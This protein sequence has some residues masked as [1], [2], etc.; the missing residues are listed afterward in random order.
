MYLSKET[1]QK[2]RE[3]KSKSTPGIEEKLLYLPIYGGYNLAKT[4]DQNTFIHIPHAI[5]ITSLLGCSGHPYPANHISLFHH[6][7]LSNMW[8]QKTR[9]RK[10]GK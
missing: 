6:C 10:I 1:G 4:I 5:K 2:E 9:E 8:S 7:I 3:K